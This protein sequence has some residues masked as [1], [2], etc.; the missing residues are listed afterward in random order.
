[1]LSPNRTLLVYVLR[2]AMAAVSANANE[3]QICRLE[4]KIDGTITQPYLKLRAQIQTVSP[5][6]DTAECPSSGDH[7]IF[8]PEQADYQ[9]PI[10]QKKWPKPGQFVHWRY[11]YL[12][13]I[14]KGD[15]NSHPCRIQH[16]PE[17]W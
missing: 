3:W 15:G 14:C 11:I 2:L 17:G 8:V 9:S 12:D 4:L 13:G 7:I 6:P 5:E 10:P 16:F 1:M